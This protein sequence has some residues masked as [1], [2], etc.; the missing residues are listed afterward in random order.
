MNTIMKA[1]ATVAFAAAL[2]LTPAMAQGNPSGVRAGGSTIGGINVGGAMK[3]GG[4][5]PVG[6]INIGGG[7]KQGGGMNPGGGIRQ[8]GGGGSGG[9]VAIAPNNRP[10][11][12]LGDGRRRQG[13]NWAA[14]GDGRHYGNKHRRNRGVNFYVYSAPYYNDYA[15]D[16]SYDDCGRFWRRYEQTGR[17][18]WKRRYYNCI[19]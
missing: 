10:N 4:G 1:A 6:G 14:N 13:G 12:G 2:S 7:I 15:D 5:N 18:V 3:Q 9:G 11:R 17:P 19:G 8:G 16:Y